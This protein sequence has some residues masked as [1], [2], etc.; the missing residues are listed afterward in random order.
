M[1]FGESHP[2]EEV[3]TCNYRPSGPQSQSRGDEREPCGCRGP[4]RPPR[5]ES[6]L[7][8]EAAQAVASSE[9]RG[10]D[11]ADEGGSRVG[12]DGARWLG[13]RCEL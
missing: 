11:V 2:T 10:V 8:D 4:I 6:L 5:D 9:L 1:H 3:P 12:L 13:R 7:V